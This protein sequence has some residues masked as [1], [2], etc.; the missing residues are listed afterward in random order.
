MNPKTNKKWIDKVLIA[1]FYILPHHLLS[2]LMYYSTRLPLGALTPKL[3]SAFVKYYDIDVTEIAEPELKNYENFNEFFTRALTPQAR[4]IAPQGVISPVDG[5]ISQI[6]V[7][8]QG[9]IFQA[10]GYDFSLEELFGGADT[11]SQF[12]KNGVFCTIYLSPRDY[13]RIHMP[14]TAQPRDMVYVPG[15]LFS[16]NARSVT[17]VPRLFARNERLITVCRSEAG[18]MALVMVGALFVGSM[19]TV[20][21]GAITPSSHW[22]KKVWRRGI[23]AEQWQVPQIIKQMQRGEEM[24]RFNMGSTVI[25]L[26]DAKRVAWLPDLHPGSRVQMGQPLGTIL[27][28]KKT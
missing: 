19:E 2:L 4:P 13:H 11:L 14:V 27:P 18:A 28:K 16:V 15:R 1:P 6:G 25:L 24:G 3:L 5:V 12:F 21:D 26:C 10:K 7:I 20:W 23:H 9:R 17:T 22:W 8:E